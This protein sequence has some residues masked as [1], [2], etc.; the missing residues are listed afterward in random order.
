MHPGFNSGTGPK[1]RE[2]EE[3]MALAYLLNILRGRDIE[4]R[5]SERALR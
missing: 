1:E 2:R 4:R 3:I 5:E